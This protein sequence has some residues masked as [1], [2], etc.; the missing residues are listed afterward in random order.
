MLNNISCVYEK[1]GE[2]KGHGRA[3]M[4]IGPEGFSGEAEGRVTNLENSVRDLAQG[5]SQI[6]NAVSLR[7]L[8]DMPWPVTPTNAS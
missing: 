7:H 4:S 1:A 3:S 5:Q 8:K 6:Q 2:R